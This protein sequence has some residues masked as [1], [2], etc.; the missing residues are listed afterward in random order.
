[1]YGPGQPIDASIITRA[2]LSFAKSLHVS[3]A[4]AVFNLMHPVKKRLPGGE[5]KLAR[6][7]GQC[8]CLR[9]RPTDVGPACVHAVPPC[10]VVHS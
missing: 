2:L 8:R 4:T 7:V 1:M 10:A 9:S 5:V 6:F 3:K